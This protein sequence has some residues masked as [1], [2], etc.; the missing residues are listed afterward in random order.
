MAILVAPSEEAPPPLMPRQSG[1]EDND[2]GVGL[3]EPADEEHTE[4]GAED[5]AATMA[6]V[7]LL[8]VVV[9][10]EEVD[11]VFGVWAAAAIALQCCCGGGG[12]PACWATE[13][14]TLVALAAA[15]AAAAAAA[16]AAATAALVS[17]STTSRSR[18]M[19]RFIST[20][21]GNI[22]WL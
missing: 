10:G 7:G 3:G 2:D 11:I 9:L 8:V 1:D 15:S 5:V 20:N 16:A 13:P 6:V 21:G 18:S 19:H 17:L 4:E 22:F 14:S 12:R